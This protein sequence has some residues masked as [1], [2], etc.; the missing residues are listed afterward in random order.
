MISDSKWWGWGFFPGSSCA[1]SIS[2]VMVFLSF[3]FE[4]LIVTLFF[5][6]SY[7]LL[8]FVVILFSL[9]VLIQ[10]LFFSPEVEKGTS[11]SHCIWNHNRRL[12]PF[13]V[14]FC[15]FVNFFIII[16]FL[17][18]LIVSVL[19]GTNLNACVIWCCISLLP[20]H[21]SSLTFTSLLWFGYI[22]DVEIFCPLSLLLLLLVPYLLSE[23]CYICLQMK[24]S[25]L[26]LSH[27]LCPFAVGDVFH[28]FTFYSH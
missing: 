23:I 20:D 22:C 28:N 2:T 11:L 19:P 3:P 26:L 21:P 1:V 14:L 18:A 6:L 12:S 17:Q 9:L 15:L 13:F 27:L 7:I 25:E 16:I 5:L 10:L 24:P 4:L 8:P